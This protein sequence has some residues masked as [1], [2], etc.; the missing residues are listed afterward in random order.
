MTT[1]AISATTGCAIAKGII[2]I[3]YNNMEHEELAIKAERDWRTY[4]L[5]KVDD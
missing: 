5:I 4:N 2:T 3:G 1:V